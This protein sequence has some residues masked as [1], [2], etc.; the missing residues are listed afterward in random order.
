MKKGT[1]KTMKRI[2]A[3]LLVTATILACLSGIGSAASINQTAV[4]DKLDQL[5]DTY[6]GKTFDG[7]YNGA[8]SCKGFADMIFHALFGVNPPA[9]TGELYYLEPGGLNGMYEI[10]KIKG[11][12]ESQ[13]DAL[14]ALLSQARPGDYIQMKRRGRGYGHTMIVYSVNPNRT[15]GGLTVFHSNWAVSYTNALDTFTW[16]QLASISDGISLYRSR[17]YTV[18]TIVTFDANGGT[19][20]DSET[21]RT[22]TYGQPYGPLP[23]PT[24]DADHIFD[25][26]YTAPTGGSRITADAYMVTARDHTLYAHWRKSK[27]AVNFDAAGGSGAPAATQVA[28][29]G[30]IK[31]PS[32]APTRSGYRFLGWSK[33]VAAQ[34][35][36]YQPGS[37]YEGNEDVTL[38]AVWQIDDCTL[39]LSVNIGGTANSILHGDV[40]SDGVIT[41]DDLTL[42]NNILNGT[43]TGSLAAADLNNDGVVNADDAMILYDYLQGTLYELGHNYEEEAE[44]PAT[45]SADGKVISICHACGRD[46]VKILISEELTAKVAKFRDISANE[47]YYPYVR[48]SIGLG[49]MQGTSATTFAPDATMTRAM[50]VTV[51][52]RISG[53]SGQY[54][55]FF[56]DVPANAWYT[57]AVSWAAGKGITAGTAAGRFSPDD[58]VTREQAVTF[59]Y[60]YASILNA[61][62][63]SQRSDLTHY[64]DVNQISVYAREPISW[65]AAS[66]IFVGSG[67]GKLSPQG[68]ATRAQLAKMI[69]VFQDEVMYEVG[70]N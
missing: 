28:H 20:P 50:L 58:P 42:L 14:Y 33:A 4:E 5:V 48:R 63:T 23:V 67:N 29:N 27:Y 24:Y 65:A 59:L 40:N 10:G 3:I 16:A 9:Y 37:S 7:S 53:D 12:T 41:Q 21:S 15:T 34:T 38:H 55:N 54:A 11:Y 60:R 2:L 44:Y 66:T 62:P 46:Q 39:T 36:A 26:W 19:L 32:Q 56:L 1:N 13:T 8:T 35:A 52:Y 45:D 31:L 22:L 47:W 17:S 61:A 69:V 25:G 51:L 6:N 43:T 64:S 30:S 49:T 18:S 57:K 70:I 68:T